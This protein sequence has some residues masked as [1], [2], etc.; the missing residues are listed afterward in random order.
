MSGIRLSGTRELMAALE[1]FHA[2][3]E[4]LRNRVLRRKGVELAAKAKALAPNDPDPDDKR[5][6]YTKLADSVTVR[7]KKGRVIV[8]FASRHAAAQ[9]ERMDY[10]H[11]TGQAKFLEQPLR[12]MR[13]S[14]IKD[15]ADEAEAELAKETRRAE[16]RAAR[17]ARDAS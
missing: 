9:H 5:P 14:L 15:L 13:E 1:R 16:R 6:D 4:K 12:A 7:R 3:P 11:E 17:A 10:Q 8:R 2:V